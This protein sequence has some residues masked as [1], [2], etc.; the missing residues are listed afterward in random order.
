MRQV[1]ISH[2]SKDEPIVK[3]FIDDILVGSLAVKVSDIFCTTTDGTKIVSGDD[4]R[5]SIQ[6]HLANAKITFL[7][8]TSFYKES[9][10][11]LNEM[12]AAWV[13]SAKVI[14][15]IVE[16]IKYSTV[17]II[18]Q[19]KQ[20]E[21]LLDEKALDRVKDLVQETLDI[22][23]KEIKSDRWTSKKYEFIIKVEQHIERNPFILPLSRE[24]FD[25]LIKDKKKLE[26]TL[27]TLIS[28]KQELE[29]M[30]EELK[31]TK[32]KKA[33]K[34]I[35]KKFGKTNDLEEFEALCKEVEKN[36]TRFDGIIIGVIYKTF[37]QKDV[38]VRGNG[39]ERQLENAVSRDYIYDNDEEY[40]ADWETT[41]EMRTAYASLNEVERFINANETNSSFYE[42]YDEEYEAP[43]KMSNLDFW[44]EAF[45]VNVY[46][47]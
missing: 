1:F 3:A 5:N 31:A 37:T 16:P 33:V 36:L 24:E 2:S 47:E 25:S 22:P 21:K 43:L 13:T 35:E 23:A 10:V 8:I 6:E 14:P 17:G 19:P 45:N 15:L 29:K 7:I 34:E 41:K 20:V 18:Q 42:S 12:G 27:R 28:D 26:I 39:W 9:E 30:N 4:W 46:L 44:E 40:V 38:I 11:C 32:D